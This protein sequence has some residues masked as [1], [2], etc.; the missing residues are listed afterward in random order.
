M[1]KN[2]KVEAAMLDL[3]GLTEEMLVGYERITME[4][5]QVLTTPRTE[6]LLAEYGVDLD[7]ANIHCCPD[8]TS[9]STVNGKITISA[10]TKPEKL[11]FLTVNG[12]ALITPDAAQAL[13]SYCQ[14][15]VNGKILCPASLAACVTGKAVINGK[16]S[17]YP[18]EAV[19]MNGNI[20][21][22]KSFVLRAADRLYWTD[23]SVIAMDLK[24][25]VAALAAKSARFDAARAIIAES[26]AEKLAPLFTDRTELIVLPDGTAVV[27]DDLELNAAKLRRYGNRIYVM[28]DVA[29]EE[30]ASDALEKLEYLHVQGDVLLPEE[31]EDA[32]YGIQDADYAELR[33]MKGHLIRE[34]GAAEATPELLALYPKGITFCECGVVTVD[35][36]IAP[37]TILA[38]LQ[39][40]S[41]GSVSCTKAQQAAVMEASMGVAHISLTDAE[42]E[43]EETP[44]EDT[45]V[46]SGAMLKL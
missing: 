10:A 6:K 28:G 25:D 38:M 36:A 14:I 26:L 46:Y 42:P 22:D 43:Q 11:T 17:V 29:V 15:I 45:V 27:E 3:S 12:K 30:A 19:V 35:E 1:K 4:A 8:E 34:R 23:R 13:E 5:A 7:A 33:L 18:D 16:M 40:E 2:L 32:F 24:L 39:F 41:C 9:I 37:E 20:R 21:L 44:D 31:L